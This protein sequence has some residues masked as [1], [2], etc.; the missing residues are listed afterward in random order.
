MNQFDQMEKI[1]NERY[2]YR[3]VLEPKMK[4]VKIYHDA[5]IPWASWSR[6]GREL[7]YYFPLV[8]GWGLLVMRRQEKGYQVCQCRILDTLTW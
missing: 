2:K 7:T 4:A 3:I 1:L 5:E 8:Y 6:I